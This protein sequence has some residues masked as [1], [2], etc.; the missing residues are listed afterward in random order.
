M[1]GLREH[2]HGCSEASGVVD[3]VEYGFLVVILVHG[4]WLLCETEG[5]LEG[6]GRCADTV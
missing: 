2:V 6:R 3:L 5:F 1:C 4:L